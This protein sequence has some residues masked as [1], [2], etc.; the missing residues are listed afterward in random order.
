MAGSSNIIVEVTI[1]FTEIIAL[2][3]IDGTPVNN[4]TYNSSNQ[5]LEE[6]DMITETLHQI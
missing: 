5:K 3:V 2:I 6:E 1:L 4:E